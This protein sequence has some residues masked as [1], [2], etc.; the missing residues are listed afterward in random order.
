MEEIAKENGLTYEEFCYL[1]SR[2]I[3]S[4]LKQGRK[5][6]NKLPERKPKWG[7][8]LDESGTEHLFS[9]EELQELL[10]EIVGTQTIQASELKG[11]VA[12]KG[13][14][15]QGT[16]KVIISPDDFKHFEEGDILVAPETTP[17]FVPL[18]K[19]AKAIITDRGG[20]TSHAAIVSREIG[21]ACITGTNNATSILKSG[22]RIEVDAEKGVIR[23]LS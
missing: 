9:G 16:A 21:I 22:E 20:I 2:E 17:D 3:L 15:I 12:S 23:K 14:I 4:F 1:S 19:K 18:M 8:F 7:S 11:T 6:P 5:L 13:G 10:N